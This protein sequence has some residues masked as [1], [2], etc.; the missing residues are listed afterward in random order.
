MKRLTSIAL[1]AF[2]VIASSAA[3]HGGLTLTTASQGGLSAQL[4]ASSLPGDQSPDGRPRVDYTVAVRNG[5]QQ[6]TDAEVTLAIDRGTRIERRRGEIVDGAFEILVKPEEDNWRRWPA[7]LTVKRQG[8]ALSAAY[9]PP[10]TSAPTW[11]P[12]AG[13]LLVPLLI[14]AGSRMVRKN[15]EGADS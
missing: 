3:G 6:V 13:V 4:T 7:R 8:I 12:Y 14:F 11:L 15:R 5:R 9:Q 1:I 2:T 10:D